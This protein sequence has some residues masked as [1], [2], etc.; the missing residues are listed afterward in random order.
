M[1]IGEFA[2]DTRIR[3][4]AEQ[5]AGVRELD[6]STNIPPAQKKISVSTTREVP[7]HPKM[8]RARGWDGHVHDPSSQGAQVAGRGSEEFGNFLA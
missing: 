5:S 1:C 4:A 7:Y 8:L 6:A 2:S 3:L